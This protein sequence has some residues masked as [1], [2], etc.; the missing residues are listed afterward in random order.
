MVGAV[1]FELTTS[2]TPSKR[3]YQATL[4]PGPS[5]VA[6]RTTRGRIV[7]RRESNSTTFPRSSN[8]LDD[9]GGDVVLLRRVLRKPPDAGVKRLHQ[10][11]RGFAAMGADNFQRAL[12]SKNSIVRRHGF[13]DTVRQEQH[14]VA[15]LQLDPGP[16]RVVS[17]G[18]QPQRDAAALQ[19]SFDFAL[20][21][22]N[23]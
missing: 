12:D 2:C 5:C 17:I 19:L 6:R 18:L 16:G 10:F 15:A 13:V 7:R 11:P 9:H 3:A 4:R 21:A 23:V 1:R 20:A 14:R 22:E 8:R